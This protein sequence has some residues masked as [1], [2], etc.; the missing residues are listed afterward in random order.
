VHLPCEALRV[1]RTEAAAPDEENSGE[2]SVAP[3]RATT[4]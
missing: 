3:A 4:S 2:P 1:L